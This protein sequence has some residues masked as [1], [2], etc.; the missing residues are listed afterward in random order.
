M[1]ANTLRTFPLVAALALA[2]GW[3]G[4]QSAGTSG[5]G[6][7]G[8]GSSM[9]GGRSAP[10]AQPGTGTRNAETNKDDKLSRGDRKFI[11]EVAGGGMYEVQAAQ[12]ASAKATNPDVKSFASKLVDDH[13]QANNELVQLANAKKVELPAAPPRGKRGAI[14][15]LGKKSGADFDKTFMEQVGIKDHKDDIKKFEKAS[16]D[17]KDP[18]LKAWVDKTL[19][20]LREHLAMAEKIKAGG[21]TASMGHAGSAKPDVGTAT[22]KGGATGTNT[23][24]KTGS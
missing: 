15:K 21:S 22:P 5:G 8:T 10:A 18:E 2:S 13:Q 3:A 23:G 17:V 14:E 24:Q 1:K 4:A 6:T 11:E 7:T 20:H 16:K 19:P 12:L 9:T